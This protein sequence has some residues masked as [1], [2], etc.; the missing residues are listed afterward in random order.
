MS[1]CSLE[2]EL[3][4]SII[5]P[6][7]TTPIGK[8]MFANQ[9]ELPLMYISLLSNV[10]AEADPLATDIDK[11]LASSGDL[12]EEINRLSQKIDQSQEEKK[13]SDVQ[14]D[15]SGTSSQ[16]CDLQCAQS[17]FTEVET[18]STEEVGYPMTSNPLLSSLSNLASKF[19]SAEV[20]KL[21]T[22]ELFQAQQFI[23]DLQNKVL[24]SL[25]TRCHSPTS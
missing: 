23:S 1:N 8:Q 10:F 13:L 22:E 12:V 17:E 14:R 20:Q 25:R 5:F 6:L 9:S 2:L 16:T 19:D 3:P 7:K 11:I 4:G 15:Q 24:N 18:N 21:R